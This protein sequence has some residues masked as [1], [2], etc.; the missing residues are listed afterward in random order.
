MANIIYVSMG[1]S[2]SA[3]VGDPDSDGRLVG[4]ARRTCS[5][6][7]DGTGATYEFTNLALNRAM[8]ADVRADQVPVLAGANP[9]LIT[10][11]IGINDIQGP[12]D[13]GRFAA[14]VAGLFADLVKTGATVATIT[15]PDMVHLLPVPEPVRN[16]VRQSIE[17]ANDGIRK[18]ADA[19]GALYVDAYAAPE[20]AEPTFW[21]EDRKHPST[22]GHT[23][24]AGAAAEMLLAAGPRR[25]VPERLA[26]AI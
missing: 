25:G 17:Q 14:Q 26:L 19:H 9:D 22:L 8:L 1:D 24:I 5:L 10:V 7:A 21:A 2:L 18:G 20:P 11:T 6:L 23:L 3:G 15:I 13:P 12:F 16:A 4:W